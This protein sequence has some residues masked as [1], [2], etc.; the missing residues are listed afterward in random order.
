ME[1][2]QMVRAGTLALPPHWL[3]A[4]PPFLTPVA[5]I[6]SVPC[7]SHQV[8]TFN[9]NDTVHMRHLNPSGAFRSALAFMPGIALRGALHMGRDGG[10]WAG[11]GTREGHCIG[12]RLHCRATVA[13]RYSSTVCSPNLP[14]FLTPFQPPICLSDHPSMSPCACP[15]VCCMPCSVH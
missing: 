8:R 2:A 5:L 1:C 13:L 10:E 3:V 4:R 7:A 6:A 14:P 12:V 11:R 15:S 9:L